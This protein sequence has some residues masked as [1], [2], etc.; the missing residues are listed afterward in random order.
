MGEK[1]NSI[2]L[3]SRS[4]TP[5]KSPS[6]AGAATE[7]AKTARSAIQNLGQKKKPICRSFTS[8]VRNPGFRRRELSLTELREGMKDHQHL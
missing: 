4:R 1:T 7:A 5:S 8:L 2:R 3:E 6:R